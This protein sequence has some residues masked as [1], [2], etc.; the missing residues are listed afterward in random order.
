MLRQ[1]RRRFGHAA[2]R[3][4]VASASYEARKFGV[5]SATPSSTAL[6]RCPELIFTPLG[7]KAACRAA[8]TGLPIHGDR[9][10]IVSSR[11]AI[12]RDPS[13]GPIENSSSSSPWPSWSDWP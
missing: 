4:V 1:G 2:S 11:I 5:R 12:V 9:R 3:A 8:P 13:C 7:R 10:R 6:R